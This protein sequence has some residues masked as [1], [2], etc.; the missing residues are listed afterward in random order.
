[1]NDPGTQASATAA[2]KA[3]CFPLLLP[4]PINKQR[5]KSEARGPTAR[6]AP[7]GCCAQ[8]GQGSS[9]AGRQR[10]TWP[11]TTARGQGAARGLPPPQERQLLQ[12]CAAAPD[13]AAAGVQRALRQ[14]RLVCMT[15]TAQICKVSVLF[16]CWEVQAGFEITISV[17][18]SGGRRG[19]AGTPAAAAAGSA[20]AALECSHLHQERG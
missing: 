7:A 11:G 9:R 6:P 20:S 15:D 1:M 3:C 17:E 13:A 14:V 16:V 4:L 18:G 8:S 12:Q 10:T 5:N 2:Q 19:S